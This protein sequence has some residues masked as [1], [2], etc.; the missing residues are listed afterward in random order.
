MD[1]DS[2]LKYLHQKKGPCSELS[3]GHKNAS[4]NVPLNQSQKAYKPH[5]KE[6]RSVQIVVN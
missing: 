4:E 1:I 3:F 5:S 6:G 2:A